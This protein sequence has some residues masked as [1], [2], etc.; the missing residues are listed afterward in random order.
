MRT[1]TETRERLLRQGRVAFAA[2]GH[3]G[4]SLQRDV[5]DPAGVSNGSFYHQFGDKTELLVAILEDARAK[6]RILATNAAS[7]L[8]SS[9]L[10]E[11]IRHQVSLLL[12]LV[13]GAED[14]HRIQYR[15]RNNADKRVRDL[16]T[17]HRKQATSFLAWRL[18][19]EPSLDTEAFDE[20]LA[21]GL[22][23]SLLRGVVTDYLDLPKN[24]RAA[25]RDQLVEGIV[26]FTVAGLAGL[27]EATKNRNTSEMGA[28]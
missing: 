24:Q 10:E 20:E 26:A 4:V 13:D 16:L 12:Y 28:S 8:G 22:V 6:G 15:E 9:T 18:A 11:R 23:M 2:K 5:L 14:L 17:K 19:S 27:A 3:D 21:A 25:K 1:A 7:D